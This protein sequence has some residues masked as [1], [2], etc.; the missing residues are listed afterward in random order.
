MLSRTI[1]PAVTR[2][3]PPPAPDNSDFLPSKLLLSP[4]RSI[5]IQFYSRQLEQCLFLIRRSTS[6]CREKTFCL[7]LFSSFTKSS[8]E[9]RDF[10][11]IGFNR[12]CIIQ[13]LVHYQS[14][15]FHDSRWSLLKTEIN[16]Y[17]ILLLITTK[18]QKMYKI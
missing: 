4:L 8:L 15:I 16:H 5:S 18:F 17:P 6:N 13:F 9:A 10:S 7:V 14:T 1:F 3:Q 2:N 11:F 12:T